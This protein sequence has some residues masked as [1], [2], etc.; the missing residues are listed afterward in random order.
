MRGWFF[1]SSILQPTSW[2]RARF[3]S[4]Y[5]LIADFLF[6]ANGMGIVF[7]S[8]LFTSLHCIPLIGEEGERKRKRKKG[9]EYMYFMV[10]H[11]AVLLEAA[12]Y[13]L[14]CNKKSLREREKEESSVSVPGRG[15]V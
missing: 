11:F 3:T 6:G 14:P 4:Y 10:W 5:P 12:T 13:V 9:F 2:S 1:S 15:T 7:Q 8:T